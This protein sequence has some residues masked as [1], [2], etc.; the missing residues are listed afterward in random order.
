[1]TFWHMPFKVKNKIKATP[2]WGIV[3]HF[4][5]QF[6]SILSSE[7]FWWSYTTKLHETCFSTCPF[8]YDFQHFFNTCLGKKEILTVPIFPTDFQKSSISENFNYSLSYFV[9][10]IL[11]WLCVCWVEFGCLEQ[12]WYM[13]V[14]T[15]MK[16]HKTKKSSNL[17]CCFWCLIMNFRDNY[18]LFRGRQNMF[19][20]IFSTK[21]VVKSATKTLKIRWKK[22]KKLWPKIFLNRE[23]SIKKIARRGSNYFP[24]K[25]QKS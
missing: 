5:N 16:I 20:T 23:F 6:T 10:T 9:W 22:K 17:M 13:Y 12:S 3:F 19:L 1:M 11:Y 24:G 25:F 4:W 8:L 2:K 14:Y 7:Q 21:L 15:L 18:S